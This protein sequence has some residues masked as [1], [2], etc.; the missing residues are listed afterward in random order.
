[1]AEGFD[2]SQFEFKVS[3]GLR[4]KL[5][6]IE[7]DSGANFM[8]GAPTSSFGGASEVTGAA[9][10]TVSSAM[11]SA[12]AAKQAASL[13]TE[14]AGEVVNHVTNTITGY[15]TSSV[16]EI[17]SVDFIKELP[18]MIAKH[19][20]DNTM[21]VSDI[22][23]DITG[24]TE[25]KK[26][27]KKEKKQQDKQKSEFQNKIKEKGSAIKDKATK[28]INTVKEKVDTVTS[29]ITAGPDWVEKQMSNSV[30]V[31]TLTNVA[32]DIGKHKEEINK[33]KNTWLNN[34]AEGIGKAAANIINS[35]VKFVQK[36]II[37]KAKRLIEVALNKVKALAQTL[38]MKLIALL[39]FG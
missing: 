21:S 32:K 2:T 17:I 7:V 20:K 10:D 9:S 6:D 36:Q 5:K 18:N 22:I 33:Q 26:A 11:Q 25:E 8:S 30:V 3:D 1:M 16:K 39:G 28:V 15:I 35:G 31:N 4:Q 29:Y 24:G 14:L 23:A 27:E 38:I 34:T 19:T 37:E 12:A 13:S